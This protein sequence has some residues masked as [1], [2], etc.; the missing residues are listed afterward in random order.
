M[1]GFSDYITLLPSKGDADGGGEEGGSFPAL[2][3]DLKVKRSKSF[4][5]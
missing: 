4:Y 3:K 5:S 2:L 1:S